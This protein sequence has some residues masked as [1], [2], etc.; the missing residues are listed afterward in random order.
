MR[1]T[2]HGRQ[3][4]G[5]LLKRKPQQTDVPAG[6]FVRTPAT[7]RVPHTWDS[8]TH[9]PMVR[10]DHDYQLSRSLCVVVNHNESLAPSAAVTRAAKLSKLQG[11]SEFRRKIAPPPS[12][13]VTAT[14]RRYGSRITPRAEAQLLPSSSDKKCLLLLPRGGVGALT[15]NCTGPRR[16]V[17]WRGWSLFCRSGPSTST[18]KNRRARHPSCLQL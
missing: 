18:N 5:N 6:E 11:V 16:L 3:P 4:A 14:F 1:G 15:M 7:F 17:P 8:Y 12:P 9:S 10:A 2:L 13:L